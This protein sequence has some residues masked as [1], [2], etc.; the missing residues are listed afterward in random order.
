MFTFS[1]KM[2]AKTIKTYAIPKEMY[3]KTRKTF[4][5]SLI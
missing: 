3:A 4:T 5:F 2:Y 1:I